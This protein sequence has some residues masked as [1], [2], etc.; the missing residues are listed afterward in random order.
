MRPNFEDETVRPNKEGRRVY[1][2]KFLADLSEVCLKV[3]PVE[4]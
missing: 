3:L 4:S 1:S 2:I